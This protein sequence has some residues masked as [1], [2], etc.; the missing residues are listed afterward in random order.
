MAPK[1]LFLSRMIELTKHYQFNKIFVNQYIIYLS[2][3]NNLFLTLY[4]HVNQ[5]LE[6]VFKNILTALITTTK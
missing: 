2:I 6:D 1:E 4:F 3:V 5:N